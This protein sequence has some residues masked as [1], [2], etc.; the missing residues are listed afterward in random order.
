MGDVPV[1]EL[2][3][4]LGK[5]PDLKQTLDFFVI[6][7]DATLMTKVL[8]IVARLRDADYSADFSYKRAALGKQLRAASTRN[9]RYVVC[10]MAGANSIFTG[11]KLLTTENNDLEED[12]RMFAILGLKAR[13]AYK[14]AK[15]E[16]VPATAAGRVAASNGGGQLTPR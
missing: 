11:D 2:L 9:A 15:P 12:Q 1:I 5:L 3:T 8:E 4:E 14:N 16:Q 13:P 10:F 6:D 7:A